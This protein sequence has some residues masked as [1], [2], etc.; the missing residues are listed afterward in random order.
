M[1][2]RS[3]GRWVASVAGKSALP[4]RP[5][6]AGRRCIR[7]VLPRSRRSL[8]PKPPAWLQASDRWLDIAATAEQRGPESN[9][10]LANHR[11]RAFVL[12][13]HCLV[14]SCLYLELFRPVSY[15]ATR[16]DKDC[17]HRDRGGLP[18]GCPNSG[19]V[20]R[21]RKWYPL[22]RFEVLRICCEYADRLRERTA[23]SPQKRQR[24]RCIPS[25]NQNSSLLAETSRSS[26]PNAQIAAEARLLFW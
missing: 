10:R 8:F 9:P 11:R 25:S 6:P 19:P 20:V 17:Y 3:S 18:F 4:S 26:S 1:R 15:L 22:L 5:D 16:A 14:C 21:R 12:V 2:T 23:N 24:V 7:S 13:P